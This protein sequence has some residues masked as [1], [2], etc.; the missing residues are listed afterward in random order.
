M[1]V[2]ERIEGSYETQEM[3]FGK[4]YTWR[5]G[6]VMVGCGCGE[7][8]ALISTTTVCECGMDLTATL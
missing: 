2:I 5:P 4:I 8:L 6:H 1:R 7:G 3:P